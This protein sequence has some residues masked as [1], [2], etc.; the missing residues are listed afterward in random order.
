MR[1]VLEVLIPSISLCCLLIVTGYV[2]SEAIDVIRRPSMKHESVNIFFLYGFS[3]VNILVDALSSYMFFRNGEE[4]VFL[5]YKTQRRISSYNSLTEEMDVENGNGTLPTEVRKANLNMISAFTHLTGDSMRTSSVIVA[6]LISTI[7]KIPS[8]ICDAYA[9][10]VVTITI[11]FIVVP[12]MRE[13]YKAT[14]KSF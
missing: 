6:A 11:T 13:I 9:A 8:D 14:L 3:F 1:F 5:S 7:A 4:D 2:T 10:I 12:L